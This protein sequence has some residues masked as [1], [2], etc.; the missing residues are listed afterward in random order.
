[1]RLKYISLSISIY[2]HVHVHQ[3]LSIYMYFNLKI[4]LSLS[5]SPSLSLLI[6]L[7]TSLSLSLSLSFLLSLFLSPLYAFMPSPIFSVTSQVRN[8]P[9]KKLCQSHIS[10]YR[11]F[12]CDP[13]HVVSRQCRVIQMQ[14]SMCPIV[15]MERDLVRLL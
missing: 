13:L 6:S 7:S 12:V 9:M 15:L 4:F 11:Y 14:C 10:R 8:N 1:M 2:V 5:L 3:S